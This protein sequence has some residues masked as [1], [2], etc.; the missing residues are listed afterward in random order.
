[1]RRRLAPWALLAIALAWTG[2]AAE[3]RPVTFDDIMSLRTVGSPQ[4]SPDGRSV[5]YTV[6]E[7]EPATSDSPEVEPEEKRKAGRM[8]ARTHIYRVPASGGGEARQLTFGERGESNPRWSPDG[9]FIS[10]VAERGQQE[11]EDGPRQQIFVMPADGGEAWQLTSAKE[12]VT[13]YTWA[14]NSASIAYTAR[15]ALSKEDEEKRKRRE[16]ARVFEGDFRMTHLWT[17]DVA[18]KEDKRLTEGVEYTVRGEPSWSPDAAGLAFA[19]AP[20]PMIRDDRD[21]VYTVEVATARVDKITNTPASEGAPRWSPDG[22]TIAFTADAV[23]APVGDGVTLGDVGNSRLMLYDVATRQTRDVSSATFDLSPGVPLWAPDSARLFFVS[24]VRVFNDVYVFDVAGADYTRVTNGRVI[25]ALSLSADGRAVAFIMAS[26]SAPADVYVSDSTFASPR[27]VT[28]V[29]P[30][31]RQLEVGDTDVITWKSTDGLEVEGVL[32]KPVGFETTTRYPLLVVIHGGPTGAFTNNF[33]M[34][35]GDP[36]QHWAGQGWAVLYPNPRGS[37]NYGQKF[38]QGNIPDW[39]GGDYR[40]IMTGVDAAIARGIAD[41]DKLAVM[42]WSYGGYMTAWVVS[43]TTRFKA[44][45][46]GAGL[47]N[48]A[49]MYGTTDVP[50]YLAR[51]FKGVPSKTTLGL[52]NE[53]S[54]IST[55]DRVT[56]PLLILHGASDER[57]PIG[58]PM[59]FYRALKDRGKTVELVF[60]PRAGHG[61]SEHYHQRDRLQ[62]QFEWITK[63]TLGDQGRKTTP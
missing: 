58:Q 35:A 57:V 43:Q 20:T 32:L 5:L 60:Y 48:L 46:M 52:Y 53:R 29:N 31:V 34:S 7:W 36:G 11:G 59:E 13:A 49:S 41:P 40:D 22:K 61:L 62:R 54:G 47:S 16:D 8:E 15:E 6:R 21:D 23:G 50:G 42:G 1:M 24:G 9:R 56:T 27:R 51:F 25:S 63:Y 39:G 10:F 19:A 33:R 18:S 30:Q 37:T 28:D 4:L 3:P 12:G 26:A 17:I 55:I 14:P 44:A 38:M 45:M 2:L